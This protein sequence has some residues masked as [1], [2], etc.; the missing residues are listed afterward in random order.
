MAVVVAVFIVGAFVVSR[1]G[2]AEQELKDAWQ[3]LEGIPQKSF[4]TQ[5]N[6]KRT[7]AEI[8]MGFERLQE[9]ADEAKDD[10]LVF[11]VLATEAVIA[12]RLSMLSEEGAD[13]VYLDKA[14]QAYS[15]LKERLPGNSLAVGTALHGLVGVESDRFVLDGDSSHKE[16]VRKLLEQLR[17]D[18][19]FANTPFQRSALDRLNR[20]DDVFCKVTLAPAPKPIPT[21]KPTLKPTRMPKP[22]AGFVGPPIPTH[23][24]PKPPDM[25]SVEVKQGPQPKVIRIGDPRVVPADKAAEEPAPKPVEEPTAKPAE[26]PSPKPT[27]T[28]QEPKK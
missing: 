3:S 9:L 10:N 8:N 19:R 23:L 18:A 14:E 17:D 12:A 22:D 24:L 11:E 28:E 21:L 4:F 2:T 26:E 13:P 25:P 6:E 7:D 5:S 27:E 1:A 15:A 16:K 20:L